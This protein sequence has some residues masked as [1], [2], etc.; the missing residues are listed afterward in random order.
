MDKNITIKDMS[1]SFPYEQGLTLQPTNLVFEHNKITALIGESGSGKSIMGKSIVKLLKKV[2]YTGEI[3]FEGKNLLNLSSKEMETYRG[4]RIFFIPQDPALALNPSLEIGD[5]LA[6]ALEY[7]DG[8]STSKAKELVL[9]ELKKYGFD[10]PQRIYKSYSFQLSGGMKQRI[11]C[12]MASVLSP[13]WIIADEPTKG[14]DSILRK[15]TYELFLTLQ[16]ELHSGI[17]FITHDLKIAKVISDNI[18]VLKDGSLVESG[19]T[20]EVMNNPQTAY[21]KELLY[22]QINRFKEEEIS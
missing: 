19:T 8:M 11:M 13:D 21:L 14:L 6:E 9:Q 22:S 4:K 1:I 17:V 15:Q 12:A 10:D 2:A 7:H 18:V 16:R 20:E 3:L 5:Q